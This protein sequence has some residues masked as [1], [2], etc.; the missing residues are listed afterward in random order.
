M[1]RRRH[2]QPKD[3]RPNKL[4]S[5]HRSTKTKEKEYEDVRATHIHVTKLKKECKND[6]LKKSSNPRFLVDIGSPRSCIGKRELNCIFT[7][8]E[9][10]V[11]TLSHSQRRFLFA[12]T[13]FPSLG[14]VFLYLSTSMGIWPIAV[15][16]DVVTADI[17]PLLGL[18]VLDREYLMASTV[19]NRL[20]KRVLTKKDGYR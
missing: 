17:P 18:D 6:R 4:H 2:I 10:R 1:T 16:T 15:A 14:K 12:D 9:K 7:D 3:R 8:M 11:P 13:A 5:N 19:S 20:I